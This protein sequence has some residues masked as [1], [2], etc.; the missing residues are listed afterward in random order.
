MMYKEKL[1]DP[2]WQKKRLQVFN[3]DNFT[4]QC[5]LDKTRTLHV[6]HKSYQE[7]PWDVDHNELITYCDEC[8]LIIEATKKTYDFDKVKVVKNRLIGLVLYMIYD[9][10]QVDFH[11]ID[12]E[13]E[14]SFRLSLNENQIETIKNLIN[15]NL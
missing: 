4:C 11:T 12:K 5:C 8:H 14:L 10:D 7:N 2:R 13:G 6:H 1:L 9:I 3:R 15:G